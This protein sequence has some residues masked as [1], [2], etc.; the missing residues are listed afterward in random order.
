MDIDDL[1][2]FLIAVPFGLFMAFVVYIG[3]AL[4]IFIIRKWRI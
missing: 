4:F 1:M 3:A 2:G